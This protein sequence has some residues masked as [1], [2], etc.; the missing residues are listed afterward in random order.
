[1]KKAGGP[2][3]KCE[4]ASTGSIQFVRAERISNKIKGI[5][6]CSKL[7]LFIT[8]SFHAASEK[9]KEDFNAASR[10]IL[11]KFPGGL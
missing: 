2:S 7:T 4:Q 1:M 10:K 3:S 11:N 8:A 9:S 6:F 5:F